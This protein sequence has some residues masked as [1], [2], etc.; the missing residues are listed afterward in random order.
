MNRIAKCTANCKGESNLR[1][2]LQAMLIR[3]GRQLDV[4]ISWV[5][6]PVRVVKA[7][8]IKKQLVDWPV[9]LFS[10]WVKATLCNRPE[11]LL[12]GN[13]ATE[14]TRWQSLFSEFWRDYESVDPDHPIYSE[15]EES[16]RCLFIP[17][18]HH[19]DEGRGRNKV[20]VLIE[21]FCPMIGFKGIDYTTLSGNL[22]ST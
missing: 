16:R 14:T 13:Q 2:N 22:A 6:C 10:D 8:S 20:P 1:R 7:G 17:F 12:G 5:P 18:T 15:V 4:R 19:G 9:I 3:T 21:N 11:L